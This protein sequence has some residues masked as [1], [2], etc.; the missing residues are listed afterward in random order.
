MYESSKFWLDIFITKLCHSLNQGI[1]NP[2]GIMTDNNIGVEPVEFSLKLADH[3]N[4]CVKGFEIL[5]I[6]WSKWF[7]VICSLDLIVSWR[8]EFH[9]ILFTVSVRNAVN[10]CFVNS[11]C[12]W[13]ELFLLDLGRN[14]C[15]QTDAHDSETGWLDVFLDDL[16]W[17]CKLNFYSKTGLYMILAWFGLFQHAFFHF[18]P[19]WSLDSCIQNE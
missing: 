16:N 6:H 12:I 19:A 7:K 15:L 17:F 3:L 5:F 14:G 1:K 18:Y 11:S 2:T 8:L 9:L 4:L 10:V 13:E